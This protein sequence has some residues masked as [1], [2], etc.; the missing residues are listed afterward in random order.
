MSD[1]RLQLDDTTFEELLESARS[2]VPRYAST[3][4][5]HNVHDPGITLLELAAW[6]A[7]AQIYSLSRPRRDERRAYASLMGVQWVGPRP[8]RGLVWPATPAPGAPLPWGRG[9]S[10]RA[11]DEV[12][13]DREGAPGFTLEQSL[14]L[15]DA[16]LSRLT[17]TRA[18]GGVDVTLSNRQ[19]GARLQPFGADGRSRLVLTLEGSLATSLADESA[20]RV[21]ALGV[22]V[23]DSP[24]A[25]AQPR[26]A[27][28]HA[29]FEASL[30]H[31]GR[32][33][34][35]PIVADQTHG[36]LRSGVV[37]L[38][39]SGIAAQIAGSFAIEL[40]P[41]AQRLLRA[42]TILSIEPNVLAVVQQRRVSA[43]AFF[44]KSRPDQKFALPDQT[45]VLPE[46]GLMF[47]GD[48]TPPEVSFV[49]DKPVQEWR[50]VGDLAGC[51]PEDR[52]YLLDRATRTLQFGNGLNG[53]VAPLDASLHVE[54]SVSAGAAGNLPRGLRWRVQGIAG[55]FGANPVAMSSGADAF[56]FDDV[57]RAAR[58]RL[59]EQRP[60][61]TSEDLSLAARQL[62]DLAV[63]R[64]EELPVPAAACV[65]FAGVRTL[66]VLAVRDEAHAAQTPETEV[67]L[68]AAH[69]SLA[70]RLPLGQKLR[71]IAPRYVDVRIRATLVAAS[72]ANPAD[73]QRAAVDML[74]S[75]FALTASNTGAATWPFQRDVTVLALKG[76]LR[77]LDDVGGVRSVSLL[78]DGADA[79]AA[80][81][82]RGIELPRLRLEAADITVLH[83]GEQP[84]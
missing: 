8:A 15:L 42:P 62:P 35:L 75:R 60:L 39:T 11:G 30:V 54:Y 48:E 73:I 40:A 6:N 32:R 5:D 25:R 3:W 13:S 51:G 67:W 46:S 29:V 78:R 68:A 82:I 58:R 53:A 38:D 79:G 16:S 22:Q 19:E 28:A 61:V 65:P 45:F 7:D 69:R 72:Q 74:R 33:Y 63:V 50:E 41:L 36:L 56:T 26:G 55:F 64:A 10:L 83:A 43:N 23:A 52:V 12:R 66:V 71:V 4:T 34:P 1:L 2:L 17:V 31:D 14:L 27:A 18:R 9:T 47:G 49:S 59:R 76:W 24:G 84:R 21:I 37:L 20:S 81:S 80:I 77:R 70:T 44:G 57:R